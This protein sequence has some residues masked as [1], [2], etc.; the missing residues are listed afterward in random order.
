[1]SFAGTI[2][3]KLI[4]EDQTKQAQMQGVLQHQNI[5]REQGWIGRAGGLDMSPSKNI[6]K[7]NSQTIKKIVHEE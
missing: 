2:L 5:V 3:K 6:N 7:N 1:M 4:P